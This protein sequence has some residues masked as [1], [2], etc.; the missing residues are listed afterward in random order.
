MTQESPL[1]PLVLEGC[2]HF[3][4]SLSLCDIM[5]G[6]TPAMTYMWRLEE[7]FLGLVLNLNV[8]S[9]DRTQ[10][11]DL[12]GQHLYRRSQLAGPYPLLQVAL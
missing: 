1:E 2:K 6:H 5:W 4:G 7:K 3:G 9:G 8:V 11:I 10:A 12:C